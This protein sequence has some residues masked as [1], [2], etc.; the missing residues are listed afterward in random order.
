[1]NN[2][3]DHR[4][5]STIT[6]SCY[7]KKIREGEQFIPNHVFSF[8]LSGSLIMNDG[9]SIVTFEENSFRLTRKN[10]LMK[11]IKQP[12]ESGEYRNISVFIGQQLL[13]DISLEQDYRSEIKFKG[14]AVL[15]LTGHK[16][17]TGYINSLKPYDELIA[18]SNPLLASMK[19]KE[20]VVLLLQLHPE[21]SNL[22]FD[23]SEPGKL[24]LEAYMNQNFRFNVSLDRF[25]YLTGRSLSTFKRDFE[26]IFSCKPGKWLQQRRL[27]EAYYLIKEKGIAPIEVYTEVGFEDLSHFSYAFKKQYGCSPRKLSRAGLT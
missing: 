18:H 24:D 5:V 7:T 16:L 1:M 2:E 13:K 14:P 9:H 23:F 11:F 4:E 19:V 20:L 10:S 25:A 22:L 12:G 3:H 17:L 6:Y 8:Q 21:L 15:R 26:K 27:E